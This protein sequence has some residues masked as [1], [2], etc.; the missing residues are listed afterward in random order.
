M[1]DHK[2]K[3]KFE[4]EADL[5]RAF[6]K[7]VEDN[8]D[9]HFYA[10]TGGFDIVLVHK[11]NGVQIGIEAKL[12]LNTKVLL[13]AIEYQ[14]GPNGPDFRAVLVGK[15][16]ADN[17]VLAR[18]LGLQVITMDTKW[19]GPRRYNAQGPVQPIFNI[20]YHCDLPVFRFKAYDPKAWI[21]TYEDRNWHDL[22]PENRLTLPDYIPDVEA[23]HP[24]PQTLSG[25]KILAIKVCIYVDRNKVINRAVFRQMKIDPSRW[26][27]GHWLAK[28]KTRGNWVA[29]PHFPLESYRRQHPV[30]FEQIEADWDTWSKLITAKPPDEVEQIGMEL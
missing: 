27:T 28:G 29:G 6:Q 19:K 8:G 22:A 4:R 26:M 10:E 25:W 3:H 5:C 13:Q 21:H 7:C 24:A 16:V 9:W 23:G 2:L 15:V 17:A 12:T 14:S 18:K 1:W 11:V 20:G 30:V